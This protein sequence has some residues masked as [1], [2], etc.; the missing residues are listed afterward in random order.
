MYLLSYAIIYVN[1]I[2][3]EC[4]QHIYCIW[5]VLSTLGPR[6]IFIDM[7]HIYTYIS[8]GS[9]DTKI[10]LDEFV[11]MLEDYYQ[12]EDLERI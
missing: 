2:A 12:K 7:H 8:K 5:G 1:T 3:G 9:N 4:S 6:N 10:G 11:L